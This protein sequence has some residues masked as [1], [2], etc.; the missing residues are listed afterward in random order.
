MPVPPGTGLVDASC[1][2][3][4]EWYSSLRRAGFSR[5]EGLYVVTRGLAEAARMEWAAS[6]PESAPPQ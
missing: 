2:A 4:H 6:H 5:A 1:V 3:L